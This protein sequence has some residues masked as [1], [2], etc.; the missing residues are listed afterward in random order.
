[1]S[2]SAPAPG[3]PDGDGGSER[4]PATRNPW[5]W[6][7]VVLAVAVVAL[8]V[9]GLH[10]RSN[11]NDAKAD[12]EAAQTQTTTAAPAT[13]AAQ[14]QT[15]TQQSQTTADNRT[16]VGIGALAAAAAAFG[17]ARDALNKNQEQIDELEAD[18]D[19]A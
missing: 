11:A 4:G 5:L 12:G 2:A 9:W 14:Q 15:T 18:V 16:V 6:A 17:A 1:M 7:T 19:K 13:I 10:E 3:P 8:G